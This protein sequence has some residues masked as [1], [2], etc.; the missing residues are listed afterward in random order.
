M[1]EPDG[2]FTLR[3]IAALQTPDGQRLLAEVSRF[4]DTLTAVSA[5]RRSWPADLVAMAV[6]TVALRRRAQA[7]CDS[8][9]VMFFTR[10]AM[11]QASDSRIARYR[12]ARY[13]Q[14]EA[15]ADWGCGIGADTLALAEQTHATGWD[16]DPIRIAMAEANARALGRERA[17]FRVGDYLAQPPDAPALWADPS[18]RPNGRRVTDPARYAPSLSALVARAAGRPLGVKV[19]PAV[20]PRAIPPGVEAEFISAGGELKEAV[21]WYGRLQTAERRATVLP[22]G[23]SL[24]PAGVV[25]AIA[26]PGAAHFDPDPAVLRAGALSDLALRLEAWR[27][28]AEIGYLSGDAPIATP[29]AQTLLITAAMP[30]NLK[31]VKRH[32]RAAGQHV[33]EVRKRG[34]PVD[35]DEVRRAL[36]TDGDAPVVLVLTRCMGKPTAIIA[37]RTARAPVAAGG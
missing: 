20:D 4:T 30:W 6:E 9:D 29:F 33:E 11:E 2:V 17:A 1:P 16:L 23:E 32:L 27:L 35:G 21:F 14:F 22:A 15:V 28:D 12:A 3:G 13:A 26:P 37:R 36:K 7:K 10:E 8:A 34:S 24:V 25:S 31:A 19:S 5:L 18:R